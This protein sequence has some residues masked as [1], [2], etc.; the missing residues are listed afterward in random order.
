MAAKRRLRRSQIRDDKFIDTVAHYAGQLREHQRSILGGLALVFI[1]ILAVS[2]GVSYLRET[3]VE[4]RTAFSSALGELEL[5]IQDNQPDGY[6][7]A[8]QSFET[9]RDRFGGKQAGVWAVYYTGFCKEQL[10]NYQAA[11]EDYDAYLAREPDGDF[12]LAAEEGRAACLHSLGKARAAA[13]AFEELAARAGIGEIHRRQWLYRAS[14]IYLTS[15]YYDNALTTLEKL[16]ELGAGSY[17]RKVKRDL[18]ALEA[19]QG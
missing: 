4:S 16:D 13:E 7:A 15:Q 18:A 12:A 1:L 17:E 6:E 10:K 14:Q 9:L 19:L 8:L 3:D 11:M 2:W 5:A